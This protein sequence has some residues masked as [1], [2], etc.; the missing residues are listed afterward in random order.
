M[1]LCEC[2]HRDHAANLAFYPGLIEDTDHLYPA[3]IGA[4]LAF[5][6]RVTRP[7][8]ET[9]YAVCALCADAGH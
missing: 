9:Q 4:L 7:G 1:L 6:L 8:D 2:P 5:E 3:G